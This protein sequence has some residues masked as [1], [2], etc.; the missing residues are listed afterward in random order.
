MGVQ[1]SENQNSITLSHAAASS[2]FIVFTF[3]L[4][5]SEEGASVA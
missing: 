1:S 5:L 4:L 2:H 3:T